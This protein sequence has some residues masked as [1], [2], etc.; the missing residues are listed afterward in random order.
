M[1]PAAIDSAL[2]SPDLGVQLGHDP[3]SVTT[4]RGQ[5]GHLCDHQQLWRV[6]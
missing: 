4:E 5:Q 3:M 6:Q 1:A 2:V